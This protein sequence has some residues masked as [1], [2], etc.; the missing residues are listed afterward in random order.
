VKIKK[1]AVFGRLRLDSANGVDRTIHGHLEQLLGN[2]FWREGFEAA[3]GP[4]R[5]GEK[6][7]CRKRWNTF[8][9]H[10]APTNSRRRQRSSVM[11]C[12]PSVG[13][14]TSDGA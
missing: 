6:G 9:R 1:I 5:M 8:K 10:I 3:F 14:V 4:D 13:I 11:P 12:S 7:G 2:C